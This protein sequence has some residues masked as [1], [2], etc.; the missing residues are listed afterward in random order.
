[1]TQAIPGGLVVY[2]IVVS[3]TA[4]P[5]DA[6]GATVMDTISSDLMNASYT[7]MQSGGASGASAGMG[8]I[9]QTVNL[10][11]GSSITHGCRLALLLNPAIEVSM[12]LNVDT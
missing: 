10:P 1:M 5:S 9:N 4:G 2:T 3:N 12:W 6:T 7:V 8:D 11:L